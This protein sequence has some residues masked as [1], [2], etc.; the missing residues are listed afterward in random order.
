M[1]QLACIVL[2]H[3]WLVL[4]CLA[5]HIKVF[6]PQCLLLAVLRRFVGRIQTGS[7]GVRKPRY[8]VLK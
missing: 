2:L 4:A 1:L 8:E 6:L 3:V 5:S 7:A